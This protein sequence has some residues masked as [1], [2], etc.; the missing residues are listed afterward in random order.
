LIE[1]AFEMGDDVLKN[2]ELVGVG[3]RGWVVG[4]G[5]LIAA[6]SVLVISCEI[7]DGSF[8]GL[9]YLQL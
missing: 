6:D 2:R 4:H 9:R 5:R 7:H 1:P 3:R 8:S